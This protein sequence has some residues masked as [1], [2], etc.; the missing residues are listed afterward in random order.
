MNTLYDHLQASAL[1]DHTSLQGRRHPIAVD[2]YVVVAAE[3]AADQIDTNVPPQIVAELEKFGF[4]VDFDDLT[5][6]PIV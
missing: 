2:A 1:L 5:I 6:H 3:M 4:Y